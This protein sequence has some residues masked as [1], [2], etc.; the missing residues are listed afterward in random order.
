MLRRQMGVGLGWGTRKR[1]AG[2]KKGGAN[3]VE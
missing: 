3:E 1:K 2:R